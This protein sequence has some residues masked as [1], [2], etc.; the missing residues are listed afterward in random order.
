MVAEE[1]KEE[2][3]VI[4]DAPV[5]QSPEAVAEVTAPPEQATPQSAPVAAADSFGSVRLLGGRMLIQS[6]DAER[7]GT[8]QGLVGIQLALEGGGWLEGFELVAGGQVSDASTYRNALQVLG[9][10]AGVRWLGPQLA[11]L[12]PT[13][14]AATTH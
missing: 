4:A 5:E 10:E 1:E 2:K 8:T 3:P 7:L 9:A 14:Y 13:L 11:N 6:S 12:T